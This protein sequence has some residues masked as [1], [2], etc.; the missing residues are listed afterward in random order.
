MPKEVSDGGFVRRPRR[1]WGSLLNGKVFVLER[2][3]DFD[4]STKG[5][6]TQVYTAARNLGKKVRTRVE[7]DKV[8]IQSYEPGEPLKNKV[9]PKA[10]SPKKKVKKKVSETHESV[11]GK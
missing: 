11:A 8:Y 5:I 9:K 1:D 6:V 7:G 10:K 3:T 4:G 2:G